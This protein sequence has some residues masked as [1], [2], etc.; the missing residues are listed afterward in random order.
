M[1]RDDQIDAESA[2]AERG[3]GAA[4]A[5]VDRDDQV[6]PFGVQPLDGR[7]LQPVAVAQAF[8]NEMHDLAAEHLERAPQD[9][10]RRDPVHVVIAVNRDA[11][12]ARDRTL[13]PFDRLH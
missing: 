3:V 13:D 10:G 1:V 6:H 2:G 5:A 4:D 7:C 8:R 9:H 12:L 11:L